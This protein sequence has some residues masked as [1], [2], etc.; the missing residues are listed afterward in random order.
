[1]VKATQIMQHDV[2][3]DQRPQ[4]CLEMLL[5][6]EREADEVIADVL[7]A[8]TDHDDEGANLKAEAAW[9]R[10]ER[11]KRQAFGDNEVEG[12]E[13]IRRDGLFDDSFSKFDD[14]DESDSKLDDS[15]LPKTPAGDEHLHKSRALQQRLRDCY[16][17]LHKVKFIQGDIYH[18]MGESKVVEEEL[19]YKAADGIRKKLLKCMFLSNS[20]DTG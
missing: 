13:G 15:G 1:M 3:I 6:A 12:T 17:T 19:A 10:A 20:S 11:R 5:Q 8:I 16:L 2:G 7:S 4:N 9:L 18:W 14:E